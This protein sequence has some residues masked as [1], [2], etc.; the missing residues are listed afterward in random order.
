MTL[1]CLA[2]APTTTPPLGWNDT[3]D[4]WILYP[5]SSASTRTLPVASA[6]AT[7]VFDVPRSMPTMGSLT[8]LQAYL[9]LGSVANTRS[10]QRSSP[11]RKG[12]IQPYDAPMNWSIT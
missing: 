1:R 4:G 3:T 10:Y 9:G 8:D 6:Y 7:T 12:H 2:G 11:P 5:A